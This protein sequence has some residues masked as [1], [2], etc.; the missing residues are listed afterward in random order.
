MRLA[1]LAVAFAFSTGTAA[2]Q[3]CSVVPSRISANFWSYIDACG[4]DR[5]S[6][7]PEA[8]PDHGRFLKACS[9]WRARNPA[10][11]VVVAPSPQPPR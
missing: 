11:V 4:C 3:E 8:S 5:L 1:L 7:V 6:P 9:A 2:P 10:P